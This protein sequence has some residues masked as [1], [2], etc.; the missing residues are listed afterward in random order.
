[1][2]I[3]SRHPN[4][5]H[6][7]ANSPGL[8]MIVPIPGGIRGPCCCCWWWC[9]GGN[10]GLR[11]GPGI[12][13]PPGKYWNKNIIRLRKHKVLTFFH[14]LELGTISITD[15]VHGIRL[16][17]WPRW[18]PQIQLVPVNS[19][20]SLFFPD[21]VSTSGPYLNENRYRRDYLSTHVNFVPWKW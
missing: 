21:N 10:G 20:Y 4:A 14:R 11:D 5:V 17:I 7:K 9:W 6:H 3:L 19:E 1:M 13:R 12:G 16:E 2:Q 8:G 18:H 15:P